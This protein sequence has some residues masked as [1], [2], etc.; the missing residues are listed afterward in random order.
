MKQSYTQHNSLPNEYNLGFP[1]ITD[2]RKV[3][4]IQFAMKYN[5]LYQIKINDFYSIPTHINMILE[6]N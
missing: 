5:G 1:Y 6:L 2:F 4:D 3:S